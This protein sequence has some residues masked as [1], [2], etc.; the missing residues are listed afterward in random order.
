VGIK[1]NTL[2]SGAGAEILVFDII[3]GCELILAHEIVHNDKSFSGLK[4]CIIDQSKCTEYNVTW[5]DIVSIA[6]LDQK[7]S[8]LNPNRIVAIVEPEIQLNRALAKSC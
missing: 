5:K 7:A 4:Y 1:I 8:E 6:E 2:E 3:Y